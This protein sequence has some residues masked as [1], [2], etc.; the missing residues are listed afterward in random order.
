M[1]TNNRNRPHLMDG[2]FGSIIGAIIFLVIAALSVIQK[3]REAREE[4]DYESGRKTRPSPEDLPEATRRMLYGSPE[5]REAELD[6]DSGGDVEVQPIPVARRETP[7]RSRQEERSPYRREPPPPRQEREKSPYRREAPPPA[8]ERERSPYQRQEAPRRAAPQPQR[9]EPPPLPQRRSQ[10][11][12]ERPATQKR[13]AQ[14]RREGEGRLAG[15]DADTVRERARERDLMPAPVSEQRET[16]RERVQRRFGTDVTLTPEEERA[17]SRA[18]A[19]PKAAA[20]RQRTV[21][22]QRGTARDMLRAMIKDPQSLRTGI[23]FAEILGPPKAMRDNP[24][25]M[26]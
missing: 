2:G 18:K 14:A 13:Q 20:Q 23:L 21:A 26:P 10:P 25:S 19:K 24:D 17:P 22:P 3:I 5:P 8:R 4:Q 11:A 12:R 9:R 16:L 15:M 7:E 6:E 1:K